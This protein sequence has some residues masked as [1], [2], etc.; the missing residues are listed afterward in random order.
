MGKPGDDKFKIRR[1]A[2]PP[3]PLPFR[4]L[5]SPAFLLPSLYSFY[6]S[7]WLL[8][9]Y[10]SLLLHSLW[11]ISAISKTLVAPICQSFLTVHVQSK[12]SSTFLSIGKN[13]QGE[14][15][16]L[17]F[18]TEMRTLDWETSSKIAWRNYSEEVSRGRWGCQYTCNFGEEGYVPSS[19]YFGR[20]LLLVMS[21]CLY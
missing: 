4:A 6:I 11:M 19:T 21:K 13:A 3:L 5:L 15:R 9:L 18:E 2:N 16:E 17:S 7:S 20:K 14:N 12:L 8:F 10:S 1:E